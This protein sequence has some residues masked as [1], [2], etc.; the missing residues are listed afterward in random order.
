MT[1]SKDIIYTTGAILRPQK[2]TDM[3]GNMVWVWTVA[4]FTDDCFKDGEIFNPPETAENLDELL[5]DT[6]IYE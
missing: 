5:I 3:L 2:V 1:S 4:E 6:T